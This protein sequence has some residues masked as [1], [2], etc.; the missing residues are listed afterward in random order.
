[1]L[2]R[3]KIILEHYR[4]GSRRVI[5]SRSFCNTEEITSLEEIDKLFEKN[6]SALRDFEK[7]AETADDVVL[8]ENKNQVKL[9]VD[10]ILKSVL[11]KKINE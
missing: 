1:M 5:L 7:Y 11:E 10:K 2:F 4:L 9:C 6:I 8:S 3:S